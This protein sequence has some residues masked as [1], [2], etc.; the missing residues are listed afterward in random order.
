MKNFPCCPIFPSFHWGLG[1]VHTNTD[2]GPEF[3]KFWLQLSSSGSQVTSSQDSLEDRNPAIST[4]TNQVL[5]R[6]TLFLDH[7]V[8]PSQ[9]TKRSFVARGL[10]FFSFLRLGWAGEGARIEGIKGNLNNTRRQKLKYIQ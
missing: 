1:I 8:S 6:Q 5:K 3:G 7:F 9:F 2:V 4:A 10:F